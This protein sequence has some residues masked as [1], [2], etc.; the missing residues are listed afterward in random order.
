MSWSND[1]SAMLTAHTV[2]A[3]PQ[4]HPLVVAARKTMPAAYR[5]AG[6][7][8]CVVRPWFQVA[9]PDSYTRDARGRREK[10]VASSGAAAAPVEMWIAT[11]Y[12]PRRAHSTWPR[13]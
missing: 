7:R 6:R 4:R 8:I 11:G 12:A 3:V 10:A 2:P 5:L 13:D 9:A 1:W